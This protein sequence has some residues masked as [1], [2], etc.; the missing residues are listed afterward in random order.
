[1]KHKLLGVAALAAS[2]F[3]LP[4]LA[5]IRVAAHGPMT[6][7][8][9]SFGEQL[10]RG[11]EMAVEDINAKGGVMG[12]K[13]ELLI[14]DDACDP[15]QA[16]VIAN[17]AV[18]DKVVFVNGH[19]CSGSSIPASKVYAESGVLQITP[20]STNPKLTDERAGPGVF[21]TVGRDDAQG[22]FAG[23]YM[24]KTFKGKKVAIIH[25]KSAY[26]KGV[27]DE[28]QKAMN[29]AGLKEVM[30]EAYTAGEKDY[31]ALVSK[32]KAAGI[33]VVYLGGYHTEGGL[34]VRQ[35]REQGLKAQFIGADALVTEELWKITG[36]AG[37][38]ILMTFNPDPRKNPN[39]KDVVA[40]FKAKNY[41]PEGYT[42]YTYAAMQVWAEAANKA[43]STDMKKVAEVMNKT[44]FKTVVGD[45]VYDAKGDVKGVEYIWYKW[46]K[47][48][49]TEL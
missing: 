32:M 2:L 12:K 45:I 23:N 3:A 25:D 48:K 24:A 22:L 6:G 11:A 9:A 18:S 46:S 43:K 36:D 19:F 17:K 31:T 15:K 42:L 38:G 40:K 8:Y 16:V 37:E 41:D 34:I 33:D 35:M 10:K 14:G 1:M 27:A 5:Q 4:A 26:G 44:K 28:T 20:A 30:Y 21:R 39:A 47:G 13:L 7:Q 29:K 49:Y